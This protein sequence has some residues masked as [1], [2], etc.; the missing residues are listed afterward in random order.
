MCI[1]YHNSHYEDDT[2]GSKSRRRRVRDV[3]YTWLLWFA[4]IRFSS[5]SLQGLSLSQ[6]LA[7]I[8]W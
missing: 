1:L 8:C 7:R 4:S 5:W 6:L 3:W 2:K